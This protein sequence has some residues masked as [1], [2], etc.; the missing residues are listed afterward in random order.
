[1]E[2][3][4]ELAVFAPEL[5]FRQLEFC[6]PAQKLR[7]ENLRAAVKGIAGKPDHLVFGEVDRARV[8]EMGAHFLLVDLLGDAHAAGA[9][10]QR[11][12]RLDIRVKPPAN[13]SYEQL[14]AIRVAP[15][16]HNRIELPGETVDAFG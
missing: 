1:M 7:I 8:I 4:D 15:T 14:V 5:V 12:R 9:A 11:E 6:E 3:Q 10:H 16:T 13:L 2:M